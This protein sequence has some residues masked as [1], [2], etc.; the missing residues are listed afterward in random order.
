VSTERTRTLPAALQEWLGREHPSAPDGWGPEPAIDALRCHPDLVERLAGLARALPDA[1]RTFVAGCP[2]VHHPAGPA[3]AAAAGTST[4]IVR[5][6]GAPG[7]LDPGLR[8]A[9][10]DDAWCDLDPW[11]ADVTF[12]RSTDLLR[13]ALRRAYEQA[14]TGT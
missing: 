13:D 7:I 9:G 8:T 11:A 3:I 4:L 2:V 6:G 1:R 12:T 14:R 5:C 10:L